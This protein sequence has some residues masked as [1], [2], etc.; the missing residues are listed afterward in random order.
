MNIVRKK[1]GIKMINNF[2]PSSR[3]LKILVDA[4]GKIG[5]SIVQRTSM[6]LAVCSHKKL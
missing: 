5:K 6:G 2:G 4:F 3:I 1:L